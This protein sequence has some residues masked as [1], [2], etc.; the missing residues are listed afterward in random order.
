[1][2][3]WLPAL[4]ILSAGCTT[5]ALER[6]TLNQASSTT[7]IRYREVLNN[8]AAIAANPW[9]LP[10]FSSIYAGTANISDQ[11]QAS[12]IGVIARE[13]IP[14]GGTFTTLDQE[15]LD[16]QVQRTVTQNWTLDPSS[17]PETL[18]A[19]RCACWW[20]LFGP[21][22]LSPADLSLLDAYQPRFTITARSLSNLQSA[23][24]PV[25]VLNAVAPLQDKEFQTV[26]ILWNE[27][28]ARSPPG[29]K[30]QPNRLLIL[31][32]V[33]D[34]GEGYHF[35]VAKDLAKLPSGWLH[36]GRCKEVPK[37]ACYQAHCCGT[38]VWVTAE[39]MSGLSILTLVLQYLARQDVNAAYQPPPLTMKVTKSV[40]GDTVSIY[41]DSRRRPVAGP[42]QYAYPVK[43]RLNNVGGDQ[44]LRSQIAA[45]RSR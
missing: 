31:S 45:S 21:Q 25:P 38:S 24:V 22:S 34:R 44:Y 12:S 18:T 29:E 33:E 11:A 20:A 9:I 3:S 17:A 2:R 8:L 27:L 10:S 42:N 23:G 28:Q 16:L 1:M 32:Q 7:D 13:A 15:T 14:A 19:M 35:D 5:L 43:Q 41:V 40:G 4:A 36:I 26:D 37:S 39:G 30:L 6:H